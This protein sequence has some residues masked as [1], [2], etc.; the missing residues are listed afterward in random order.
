MFYDKIKRPF[1]SEPGLDYFKSVIGSSEHTFRQGQVRT[2]HS[3]LLRSH[4]VLRR[5]DYKFIFKGTTF[6]PAAIVLQGLKTVVNFHTAY[7]LGNPVSITG[8]PKA[9]ELMNN[10]YRKGLYSKTDWQI[11][12]ELI[13][14]GNAFEYVYWDKATNSIKSKVFRNKD[15]YPIYN[16][17][18]EYSYFVE[19]WKNKTDDTEHFV[20]YYPTHIDTYVNNRRVSRKKN[21][22]G[23]PIHYV[24]M[25]RSDYDQFG[26][27][28]ML[29]LI[30]IQDRVEWLLSKVD[31]GITTLSLNPVGVMTGAKL[32]E[33]DMT[34]SQI[35]GQVLCLE[36]G[37]DFKYANAVMDY[38]CI[39]YEFDQLYQQFNLVAAIPSSILGQSNIANVSENSMSMVYQL[40]ENRGKQNMNSLLDGFR[41][42]WEY[43]R[44]LLNIK[45]IRFSD[46]DFDSLNV[47]FNINKPV[48]TKQDFENM[49]IQYKIGAISKRTIMEK[50]PYTTDSAQEMQRLEE[51]GRPIFPTKT[52]EETTT[53][54]EVVTDEDTN[55]PISDE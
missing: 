33:K 31:D 4:D 54:K 18:L 39:K 21:L 42:R 49:Y 24:G 1:S 25:E 48:D 41:Q 13:T 23:L 5:K 40:T 45:H 28:M 36:E 2:I 44:K 15:S 53:E 20:I 50:S 7:L 11:L 16:E 8:T 29:D 14:Y 27:S 17:N 30:P 12:Y 26:D 34:S 37:A 10:Y 52:K 43:M 22:T 35:S 47:T 51:E 55:N 38:N 32:T 9:V 3:H 46:K 19:H 6:D